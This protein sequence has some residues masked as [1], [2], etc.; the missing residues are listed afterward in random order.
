MFFDMI[1]EGVLLQDVCFLFIY[2]SNLYFPK[3]YM[4]GNKVNLNSPYLGLFSFSRF[5]RCFKSKIVVYLLILFS[6]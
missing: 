3:V 4:V 1:C 6:F 2:S 5:R